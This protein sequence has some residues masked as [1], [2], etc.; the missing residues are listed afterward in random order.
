MQPSAQIQSCPTTLAAATP[1]FYPRTIRHRLQNRR[2]R[3][4][5]DSHQGQNRHVWGRCHCHQGQNRRVWGRCHCH[6]GQNRHVWGRCHCHQGQNRRVWGRCHCHQGQNRRVWG[7]WLS[8]LDQKPAVLPMFL[9]LLVKNA[10]FTNQPGIRPVAV[11]SPSPSGRGIKGEG[12][13]VAMPDVTGWVWI[14]EP[15]SL[16]PALSRWER[17]YSSRV[18]S[19]CRRRDVRRARTKNQNASL[20]SPSPS[21]RGIKGEGERVAM[22]DVTGWVWICEPRSLSPAL[23]LHLRGRCRASYGGQGWAREPR[24]VRL[25]HLPVAGAAAVGFLGGVLTLGFNVAS[26]RTQTRS[27][28]LAAL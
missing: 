19:S 10:G 12:E 20:R 5:W 8:D 18:W 22:P 14:C 28:L 21:G 6:E 3:S 1:A 16:S 26:A 13:R 15:F 27:A 17:E 2:F 24:P 11:R 7:Y 9:A 23:S 25:P 4:M